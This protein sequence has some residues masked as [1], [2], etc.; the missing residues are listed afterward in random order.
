MTLE[1]AY[2]AYHDPNVPTKRL[3]LALQDIADAAADTHVGDMGAQPMY[4]FNNEQFAASHAVLQARW[5]RLVGALKTRDVAAARYLLGTSLAALQDF[6]SHSNWIE[7]GH[8]SILEGLGLPSGTL[9]DVARFDE[10]TCVTC[11][12]GVECRSHLTDYILESGLLT[13]EYVTN[14]GYTPL[15]GKCQLPPRQARR[16]RMGVGGI[17]KDLPS[18]CFSPRPDLHNRAARLAAQATAHYL[19]ALRQAVG[20]ELF[21]HLLSLHPR[22]AVAIVTD[23]RKDY[24]ETL[25]NS[26][27][28]GTIKMPEPEDYDYDEDT[29]MNSLPFGTLELP[30]PEEYLLV[31]YSDTVRGGGGVFRSSSA[32][33]LVQALKS[34]L[35][36]AV[37]APR[38]PLAALHTAAHAAL[39]GTEVFMLTESAPLR[40]HTG[41]S[42][43]LHTR[44]LLLRK[45]IKV[46]PLVVG[47]ILQ[48]DESAQN[49]STKPNSSHNIWIGGN[50]SAIPLEPEMLSASRV[51]HI[52][53]ELALMTGGHV[54]DVPT[55]TELTSALYAVKKQYFQGE[56]V[57]YRDISGS[58]AKIINIT[59][60]NRVQAVG[61]SLYGTF[62]S[63]AMTADGGS[64]TDLLG[65]SPTTTRKPY[66]YYRSRHHQ[67]PVTL[68][69]MKYKV[70][71]TF[72]LVRL[73]LTKRVKYL[74]LTYFPSGVASVIVTASSATDVIPSFY[75]ADVN[76]SYPSMQ[77]LSHPSTTGM[78][79]YLGVVVPGIDTASLQRVISVELTP[80]ASP[81]S[82]RSLQLP[83]TS[84]RFITYARL[85]DSTTLPLLPFSIVYTA[86]DSGGRDLVRMSQQM[87][88]PCE[89]RVCLGSGREVWGRRGK[90]LSVHFSITNTAE[91]DETFTINA[92]DSLGY[93]IVFPR[94]SVRV[95]SKKSVNLVL[96][97][98]IPM[99]V[100]AFQQLVKPTEY[101]ISDIS[102]IKSVSNSLVI[103]ATSPKGQ[104]SSVVA[105]VIDT[106]DVE[107]GDM[108][109]TRNVTHL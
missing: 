62:V 49:Q 48:K 81:D 52:L 54:I 44:E 73:A 21:N 19:T 46:M 82:S 108:F 101:G 69:I 58:S 56:V 77:R 12:N 95:V 71:R 38:D 76:S 3:L 32:T 91:A 45:R 92:A 11:L 31:V 13:S 89:F 34:S 98:Y 15:P 16:G 9:P 59:V 88:M 50:A 39:P 86:H 25:L 35:I 20:N 94:K 23:G 78:H 93:P 30:E 109:V 40:G 57:L 37:A 68:G 17:S 74:T 26:L 4:H 53:A 22:P 102:N 85:N 7:L 72:M 10:E 2:R 75:H 27:P 70:G 103:T 36:D 63:A 107:D 14:M 96:F 51:Y 43:P 97:V 105:Y 106:S 104:Y 29:N 6:Y 100:N 83:T 64:I 90:K 60:D 80:L 66:D 55:A 79:E 61:I 42:T 8:D 87:Q 47:H 24:T 1:E 5:G 99:R 28:F 65:D 18:A 67:V 84:P 33:A 41:A